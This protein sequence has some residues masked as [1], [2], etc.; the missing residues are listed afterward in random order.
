[1]KILTWNIRGLGLQEKRGSIR[2]F[3]RKNKVDILLL[4]KTKREEMA[5][6]LPKEIGGVRDSGSFCKP[7]AGHSGGLLIIWNPS[8]FKVSAKRMDDRSISIKGPLV[9]E[10][11]EI[12]IANVYGP[13]VEGIEKI[14]GMS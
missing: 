12:G 8:V 3:I 10:G 9:G 2:R 13:N 4:H 6:L 1:M 5:N 14:S 11:V 7:T